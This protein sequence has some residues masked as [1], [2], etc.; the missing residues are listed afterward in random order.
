MTHFK[1]YWGTLLQGEVLSLLETKVIFYIFEFLHTHLNL[2]QFEERYKRLQSC[3]SDSQP[4]QNSQ[5]RKQSRMAGLIRRNLDTDSENEDDTDEALDPA[6]PWMGE[7]KRYLDTVDV[8]P[9]NMNIVRW[10]GVC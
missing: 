5:P 2:G 4:T 6:K 3:S 9:D 10:W 1:K 8:V 7:F